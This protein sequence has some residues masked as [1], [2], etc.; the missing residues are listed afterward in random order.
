MATVHFN[1]QAELRREQYADL[2]IDTRRLRADI[3]PFATVRLTVRGEP[4]TR[5]ANR[6]IILDAVPIFGIDRCMFASKFACRRPQGQL[7]LS[8]QPVRAGGGRFPVYRPPQAVG[9]KRGEVLQ[10]SCRTG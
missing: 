5:V 1:L 9:R 8:L 3:V 10:R 4:W 6:P 7:G 2:F